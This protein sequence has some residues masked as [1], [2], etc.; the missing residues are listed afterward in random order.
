[1]FV[2][3]LG[4][5]TVFVGVLGHGPGERGPRSAPRSDLRHSSSQRGFIPW[6]SYAL[7]MWA[8]NR[9]DRSDSDITMGVD[10]YSVQGALALSLAVLPLLAAAGGFS[11][12]SRCV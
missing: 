7:H 2:A 11:R 3:F 4:L 12:L 9:E 10:H 8:L 6:L 5:Q 1:M